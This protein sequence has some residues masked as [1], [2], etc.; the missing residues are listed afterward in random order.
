M[1][2]LTKTLMAG[3]IVTV[4]CSAQ[5]LFA[6]VKVG[7]N[8]TTIE[9]AS[10]LEVEASTTDRK[11]KVDKTTG[12]LTI[13]DGTEGAG[14]IL[15]SDANGGAS[16]QTPEVQNS[17]VAFAVNTGAA[18]NLPLSTFV[19]V[20]FDNKAFDKNNVF[21]LTTNQF[22]VPANG[23][24][25]Y[26]LSVRVTT[27]NTNHSINCYLYIYVNGVQNSL[28]AVGNAGA[29]SGIIVSGSV[30][31]QLN[32]GDVVDIRVWTDTPDVSVTTRNLYV[33]MASR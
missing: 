15:T 2:N 17:P 27:A 13:K 19:T 18:Q 14:K 16:W 22:T 25:Y 21:N 7:T 30:L 31:S 9:A 23:T 1:K 26:D 8:P 5:T 6:Q 12:Q 24:G 20:N 4:M 32:S 28:V 10:N 33:T 29:G 11:V 3:T